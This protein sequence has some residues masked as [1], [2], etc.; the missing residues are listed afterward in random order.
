MEKKPEEK[1]EEPMSYWEWKWEQESSPE[2]LVG[3]LVL[4]GL[5]FIIAG[6]KVVWTLLF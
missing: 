3:M 2:M 1:R 4:F 6:I 5:A